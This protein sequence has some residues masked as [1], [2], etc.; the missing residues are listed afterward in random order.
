MCPLRALHCRGRPD[1]Q[2]SEHEQAAR[3]VQGMAMSLHSL[4]MDVIANDIRSKPPHPS[5]TIPEDTPRHMRKE[6]DAHNTYRYC[7]RPNS[8][9]I[10]PGHEVEVSGRSI[11]SNPAAVDA[12]A[13]DTFHV[14]SPPPGDE[15]R[16][17]RR[18]KVPRQVPGSV[19]PHFR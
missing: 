4:G 2:A 13:D 11:N 10:E 1:P 9:R 14:N 17:S 8:G 7:V 18:C 6:M 3:C 19:C 16:P 15:A 12:K 5:S